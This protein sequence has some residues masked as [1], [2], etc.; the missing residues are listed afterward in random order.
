MLFPLS[1]FFFFFCNGWSTDQCTTAIIIIIRS[2]SEIKTTQ[3]HIEQ[4]YSGGE[5]SKLTRYKLLVRANGDSAK[6]VNAMFSGTIDRALERKQ[7]QV[8]KDEEKKRVEQKMKEAAEK[9]KFDLSL[10]LRYPDGEEKK[11]KTV[12]LNVASSAI[13]VKDLKEQ[14]RKAE[15]LPSDVEVRL[16]KK[17]DIEGNELLETKILGGDDKDDNKDGDGDGAAA[18]GDG[19]DEKSGGKDH[20]K[21]ERKITTIA[22]YG[23]KDSDSGMH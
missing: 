17:E 2:L 4:V 19:D 5:I 21:K 7:L 18:S 20:K 14:L 13:T 12:V 15:S 6:A 9:L 22:D 11:N 1:F 23:I 8:E 16:E 10:E 3:I